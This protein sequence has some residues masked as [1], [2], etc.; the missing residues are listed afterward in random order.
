ME[1]VWK[2]LH[3]YTQFQLLPLKHTLSKGSVEFNY[4]NSIIQFNSI[5]SVKPKNNC[6]TLNSIILGLHAMLFTIQKL[7]HIQK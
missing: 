4:L 5:S 7:F 2:S 1:S 3:K 6:N